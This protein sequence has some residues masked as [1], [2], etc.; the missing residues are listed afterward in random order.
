FT[1]RVRTQYHDGALGPW[2]KALTPPIQTVN[3]APV[4]YNETFSANE[5]AASIAGNVLGTDPMA[6]GFDT[7]DDTVHAGLRAVLVSGPMPGS[8]TL[9]LN[10]DGSF[11]FVPAADVEGTITFTYKANDGEWSG[12]GVTPM[13]DD[14][15]V[16]TVTL[17]VIS[18]H[19]ITT[20]AAQSQTTF[21]PAPPIVFTPP[22]PNSAL[23]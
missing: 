3:D 1:Y 4:A 23:S 15:T 8:G 6:T 20:F 21:V 19:T 10:P 11:T 16:A 12:D 7:D 14:S 2:S 22:P 13:S 9:T 18:R 5:D 17:N